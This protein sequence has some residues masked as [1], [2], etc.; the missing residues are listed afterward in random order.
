VHP[1]AERAPGAAVKAL[2]RVLDRPG[3]VA[4]LVR[5]NAHAVGVHRALARRVPIHEGSDA[6]AATSL[7]ERA[8]AAGGNPEQLATLVVEALREVAAGCDATFR[9]QTA[10]AIRADGIHVGKKVRLAPFL[11]QLA[12]LYERPTIDQW[13]KVLG[14]VVETPPDGVNLDL[15]GAMRTL[16][17]IELREGEHALDALSREVTR[18]SHVSRVPAR[19]ISTVHRAKGEEFDHVVVLHCSASPFPDDAEARRIMYVALSRARRSLTLI[20]ASRAPT[21]LFG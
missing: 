13:C 3:S 16:A 12:S 9:G 5:N 6:D 1:N 19:C 20:G 2:A 7:L 11:Q 18:R 8:I 14:A 15:P 17:A 10:D 4:I 21:P